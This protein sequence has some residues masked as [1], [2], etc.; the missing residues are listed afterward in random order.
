MTLVHIVS[1]SCMVSAV[2][3]KKSLPG[4]MVDVKTKLKKN[5]SARYLSQ[6]SWSDRALVHTVE[7][8]RTLAR[9]GGMGSPQDSQGDGSNMVRLTFYFF[10]FGIKVSSLLQLSLRL[11]FRDLSRN[12]NIVVGT[13]PTQ[14]LMQITKCQMPGG[15]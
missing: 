11:V 12:T 14:F 9:H 15:N 2:S 8:Q 3:E 6:N 13:M 4:A 5:P 7:Q 10:F 1:V